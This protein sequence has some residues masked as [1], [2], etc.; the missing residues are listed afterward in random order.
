MRSNGKVGR[1]DTL[2]VCALLV[3]AI[4]SVTARRF[5]AGWTSPFPR[6]RMSLKLIGGWSQVPGDANYC[7]RCGEALTQTLVENK[8]RPHCDKC[9]FTVF[10]DP[11]VAAVVLVSDGDE[12]LV[13]V[14]RA[15]EPELGRW[16]FPSGYVDRGEPVEDAAVREVK[17][18]TGLDVTL[19]H[20][21]GVYSERDN[22]VVLV[23]YSARVAGGCMQTGPETLEVGWHP[24]SDLPDLP[25]P[26]DHQIL[27]DWRTT[28]RSG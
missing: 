7:E 27:E 14:R 17:E 13:L 5:P 21:V 23:V 18:E 8:T 24:I 6:S 3:E 9:G 28:T 2:P 25:F 12:R 20:L 19:N 11:K 26:H 16:S 10:R 15:I 1:D 22:P 4:Q